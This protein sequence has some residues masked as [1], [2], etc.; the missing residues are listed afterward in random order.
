MAPAIPYPRREKAAPSGER[1]VLKAQVA[2]WER[3]YPHRSEYPS[4]LRISGETCE[5]RP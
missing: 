2:E 1:G 3:V 5:F 4:E